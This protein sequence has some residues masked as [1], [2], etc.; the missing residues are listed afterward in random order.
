MTSLFLL[1]ALV[2]LVQVVAPVVSVDVPSGWDVED[3]D[4]RNTGLNPEVRKYSYGIGISS[5]K[6]LD[7]WI[8]IAAND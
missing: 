6:S 1:L 2:L 4:I 8:D 3:G 7:S 5:S